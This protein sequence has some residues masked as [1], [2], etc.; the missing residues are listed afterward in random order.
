MLHLQ[1]RV[2]G[3]AIHVGHEH[4]VYLLIT[5]ALQHFLP[6]AGEFFRV[7]MRM[8]VDPMSH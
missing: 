5:G 3:R 2:N 8:C 7:D 4:L 1:H 6:V